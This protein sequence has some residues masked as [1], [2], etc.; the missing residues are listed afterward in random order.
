MG[1]AEIGELIAGCVRGDDQARARFCDAYLDLVHRAVSRRLAQLSNAPPVQ[2]DVEDIRNEVFERLLVDDC[3]ALRRIHKPQSL[4]AWLV[5]VARNHAVDYVRKRT[6]RMRA[7]VSSALE[8]QEHCGA[9]ASEQELAARERKEFVSKGL[10]ALA[11]SDRLVL[12]LYFV[13]ELKYAEIAV[14][15]SLN[16]NTVSARLRRAKAK[17][18]AIMLEDRN[19]SAH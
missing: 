17:L 10:A 15:L 14:M 11:P 19:G 5:S 18:R 3:K 1:P 12:E 8:Q 7:H 16:I 9:G 2:S 13:R 4:N 6:T